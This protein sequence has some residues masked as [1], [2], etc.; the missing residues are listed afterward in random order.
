MGEGEKRGKS[1]AG[2]KLRL[3][4]SKKAANASSRRDAEVAEKCKGDPKKE[5]ASFW[6]AIWNSGKAVP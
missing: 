4:V 2:A 6:T 1:A 5:S 3:F